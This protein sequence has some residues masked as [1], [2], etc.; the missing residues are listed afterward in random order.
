[1][2]QG[3][4]VA[5]VDHLLRRVNLV[6]GLSALKRFQCDCRCVVLGGQAET[7]SRLSMDI[8]I[9]VIRNMHASIYNYMVSIHNYKREL[10]STCI[11]VKTIS[12]I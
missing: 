8:E 7:I 1:M 4:C 5:L 9:D 6:P 11:L 2:A 10:P 12:V 3:T